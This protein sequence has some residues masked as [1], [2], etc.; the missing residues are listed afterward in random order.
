MNLANVPVDN[1]YYSTIGE[2]LYRK[3]I[4]HGTKFTYV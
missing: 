3:E 4:R 2:E 1:S